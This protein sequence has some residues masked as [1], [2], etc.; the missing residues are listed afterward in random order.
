MTQST[1]FY[2]PLLETVD[3]LPV[4]WTSTVEFLSM[5]YTATDAETSSAISVKCQILVGSNNGL[6]PTGL[7]SGQI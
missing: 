6:Y 7:K 2:S 4:A 5:S 1:G 3:A